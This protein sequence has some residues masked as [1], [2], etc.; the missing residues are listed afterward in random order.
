MAN[1]YDSLNEEL[2]TFISKQKIVFIGT[3]SESGRIHISPKSLDTFR[4]IDNNT[5][6]YLDL[7]GS[8]NDTAANLSKNDHMTM[9]FCSFDEDPLI[10]RLFGKGEVISQE[11]DSWNDYFRY[12]SDSPGKRQIILLKIDLVQTSCGT[13]VPIYEFKSERAKLN[14]WE[15]K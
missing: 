12:F 11:G 15:N 10:L 3:A 4:C 5:I 8:G 2:R 9:M 6:A 7:I 14:E 13:S 1:F